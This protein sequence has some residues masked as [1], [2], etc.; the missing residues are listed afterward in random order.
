[1]AS[2]DGPADFDLELAALLAPA[3]CAGALGPAGCERP[4]AVEDE[5]RRALAS[6]TPEPSLRE[7]L[8]MLV[9]FAGVPR[10]LDA[11]AGLCAATGEGGSAFAPGDEGGANEAVRTARGRALFDSVYGPSADR[12]LARLGSLEP[13][14]VPCVLS[15]AY[16]RVLARPGLAP[17]VRECLA[18]AVLCALRLENQLVGHVRGALRLGAAA[19]DL[20]RVLSA[21]AA[22][23]AP[24]LV[25]AAVAEARRFAGDRSEGRPQE[26]GAD[27]DERP[28]QG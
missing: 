23:A 6:G 4:R 5:C 19:D 3:V 15:D 7:S 25:A 21:A 13:A 14:V 8:L 2:P 10:A 20:R 27:E 26:R 16:G 28:G 18:V 11:F 17:A 9:P 22:Y 12:V 1:M 24:D